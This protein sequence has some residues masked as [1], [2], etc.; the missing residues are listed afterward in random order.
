MMLR[1]AIF[2]LGMLAVWVI[3]FQMLIPWLSGMPFFPFFN[4]KDIRELEEELAEAKQAE[5]LDHID[6]QI[7]QKLEGGLYEKS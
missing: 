5:V 1:L 7:D 4:S 3:I 6:E 2:A